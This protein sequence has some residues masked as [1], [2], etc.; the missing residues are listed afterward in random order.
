MDAP[1]AVSAA[2]CFTMPPITCSPTLPGSCGSSVSGMKVFSPPF[3]YMKFCSIPGSGSFLSGFS[4]SSPPRHSEMLWWQPEADTPMNGFDR[5]QAMRLNSR[6]TWAQIWRYVVSRSAVR[7]ASSKVKFSSSWP[8]ASSWSPWIMSRPMAREVLDHPQ[9]HRAQALELVDVVAVRVGIAAGGFAVLALLEPHH[10]GLRTMAQMQAAVL[11]LELR[12]DAAQIAAA[13]RGQEGARLLPL[14]PIAEQRAPHAPDALVPG[15]LAEGLRLGDAHQLLVVRPVAEVLAVPV[16]EQVDR[17]P[18]H[19]LET[20]LGDR[21]PVVCR[22]ALAANPSGDRHELEVDVLDPQ[23]LDL[24]AHLS[25]QFVPAF[26]PYE[27]FDIRHAA[28]PS[29]RAA[30]SPVWSTRP[31]QTISLV[32]AGRPRMRRLA[33]KNRESALNLAFYGRGRT[34]QLD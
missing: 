26:L 20:A 29:W 28:V 6:A 16:Q 4:S 27:G 14:F 23:L 7:S 25:D 33:A 18:V 17:R 22:D 31:I 30:P 5:K 34:T 19:E 13:I 11:F 3:R 8:G 10:L 32:P 9:V 12:V 2:K 15:Q 1:M 24:A 21:F